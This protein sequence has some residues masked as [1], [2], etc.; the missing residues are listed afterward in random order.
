MES[1]PTTETFLDLSLSL[2]AQNIANQQGG[3]FGAV[4][5]WYATGTEEGGEIVGLGV[6]NV[7]T[8]IDPTAHAEVEAMRHLAQNHSLKDGKLVL[9][10]S[11][12]C[13]PMC[14]AMAKSIGVSEI[15]YV[16]DRHQAALIDFSDEEQYHI[17]EHAKETLMIPIKMLPEEI[18]YY[19]LTL[20]GHS[21]A[22]ILH[23]GKEIARCEDIPDPKTLTTS[24]MAVI[25]QACIFKNHFWLGP[26]YHLISRKK[27]H[28]CA[29]MACDWAHILRTK[30]SGNVGVE[31]KQELYGKP[32][33]V[34]VEEEEEKMMTLLPHQ[35]MRTIIHQTNDLSLLMKGKHL[36]AQWS[37]GIKAGMQTHY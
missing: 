2:A 12:E 27:L 6:N 29:L 21:E 8:K 28:L 30:V 14:L 26:D 1:L 20:L 3:P 24:S 32:R 34:Y 13:C 5:V 31:H 17:L 36:F 33:V 7:T 10:S 22:M 11:S 37:Q 18:S 16:N 23:G 15:Y 19:Y 25:Q 9:Y 4:L 35:I